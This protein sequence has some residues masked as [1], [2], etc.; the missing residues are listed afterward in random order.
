[1]I[2][3]SGKGKFRYVIIHKLDRFSRDK[4]DSVTYKRKLK[5]NGVTLRSVLENL[6]GSP[7]S[8]ILESLL[9]GMAAYYSQN[10]SR[11]A[12]KGQLENGY[13][14]LHN[15]GL[16]PLGYDIDTTTRKYVVN[17]EEA[18]LVRYIFSQYA[19][20][21][22]YNKIVAHLN[23]MG[24][25]S[26]RGNEFGKN[27]LYDL[28]KN[29]KYI[30]VYTFNRKLE[31]DVSGARNPQF[32]P[33]DEW[34]YIEGGIPAI[35]ER[36]MFDKV[37]AKLVENRKN[38]GRFKTKR[39]YMLTGL[40]RCGECGSLMW[41]KSHID[42][43][44]RLL[45]LNYECSSKNFKQAC[46]SRGIRKEYIENYIL[47]ELRSTLFTE[48]SIKRLAAMLNAYHDK[49]KG[50]SQSEVNDAK[51]ELDEIKLKMGRII[52]LVADSGISIDVVKDE[53]KRLEERKLAVEECIRDIQVKSDAAAISEETLVGLI[54][55]SK[56][57]IESRNITECRN[58]VGNY[59]E[60]VTVYRDRVDIL[61][62]IGVPDRDS[63]EGTGLKPLQTSYDLIE[64]KERYKQ[65]A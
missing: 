58:L 5:V 37:Q 3:D 12:L 36:E 10:L 42:G 4:Y 45:Y 20:G 44:H 52:Q 27:S 19:E 51:E 22:G 1:M 35:I 30:G 6:D 53:L 15:G 18:E 43:R 24:Y 2:E 65:T 28:L 16:P 48:S 29:P 63:V 17:E 41:G 49:T 64:L 57:F 8:L 31:K 32:K 21:T 56:D 39:V 46:Q 11:E 34:I 50:Q 47:D 26:K 59:I 40:I 25:R 38:A 62:K 23:S 54:T 14:C 9:E 60:S 7:E 33:K 61:F 55:K 13:K